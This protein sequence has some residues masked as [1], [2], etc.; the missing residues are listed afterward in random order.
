MLFL[1]ALCCNNEVK[2]QTYI[3]KVLIIDTLILPNDSFKMIVNYNSFRIQRDKYPNLRVKMSTQDTSAIIALSLD[4]SGGSLRLKNIYKQTLDTF[5]ISKLRV[6]HNC[7][8]NAMVESS[9]TYMYFPGYK[10]TRFKLKALMEKNYSKEIGKKRCKAKYP[11]SIEIIMNGEHLIL[12]MKKEGIEEFLSMGHGTDAK[13]KYH[14]MLR[15]AN[16]PYRYFA[17]SSAKVR[18][19]LKAEINLPY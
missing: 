3:Q 10:E 18:Y 16:L 15:S 1:Y 4:D 14:D 7:Y 11:D 6:F 2:G 17:S 5:R 12:P 19:V 8:R 13:L 9:N